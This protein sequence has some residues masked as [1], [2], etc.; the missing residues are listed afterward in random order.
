[1]GRYRLEEQLGSGG[2]AEVWRGTDERLRRPVAIKLLHPHLLRDETARGRF[3]REA[4]AAAALSHPGIVT[5]YDVD[6]SAAG[7]AIVFELVEGEALSERLA[8]G[9]VAPGEAARIAADLADA[10]QHAHERGVVHRDVKPGNVLLDRDGR[11]RLADFGIARVIEQEAAA[12]TTADLIPGTL[13][14]LA[15][16][17]LA[18]AE[19][20]ASAD[21]YALGVVLYEMVVGHPPFEAVTLLALAEAQQREPGPAE[22]VPPALEAIWRDA[23]EPDPTKR[24]R[25][26]AAMAARLRAVADRYRKGTTA[27]VQVAPATVADDPT[28]AVAAPDEASWPLPTRRRRGRPA[29]VSAAVPVFGL[30]VAAVAL[31]GLAG[32]ALQPPGSTVPP[33][34]VSPSATPTVEPSPTAAPTERPPASDPGRGKGKGK[35]DGEDGDD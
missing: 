1:M 11:A 28:V 3:D 32:Q 29:W 21:L 22:G 12:L 9:P 13:R 17:R 35:G 24:P 7:P 2:S 33:P 14:Y 31:A 15:P 19:A 6:A 25:D 4:R 8:R 27:P 20:T 5:V 30:V 16:E 26:A 23:L 18:G 10:L 34:I